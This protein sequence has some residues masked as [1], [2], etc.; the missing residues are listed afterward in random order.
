M[1]E[2]TYCHKCDKVSYL[3]VVHYHKNNPCQVSLKGGDCMDFQDIEKKFC[4]C[5]VN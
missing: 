1:N 2:P 3:S 5:G 4:Y